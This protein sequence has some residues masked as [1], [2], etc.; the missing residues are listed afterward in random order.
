MTEN[1]ILY[2]TFSTVINI[3]KTTIE[4]GKKLIGDHLLQNLNGKE[5]KCKE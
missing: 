1:I 5:K 3:V 2:K 4:R